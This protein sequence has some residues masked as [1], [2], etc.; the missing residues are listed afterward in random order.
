MMTQ[1][2]ARIALTKAAE[3]NAYIIPNNICCLGAVATLQFFMT[4]RL[5]ERYKAA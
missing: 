1:L 2:R 5:L 3:I 4:V